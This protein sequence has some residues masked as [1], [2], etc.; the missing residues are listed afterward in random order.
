M[1]TLMIIK[2][3]LI[4]PH[5]SK[6]LPS[7]VAV[8]L[9]VIAIITLG[10]GFGLLVRPSQLLHI[11]F[12]TYYPG[13]DFF[14]R[15]LGST[16]VGYAGLNAVAARKG[17]RESMETAVWGNLITLTIATFVSIRYTHLFSHYAWLMIGQHVVF[18]SGFAYCA[19]LLKKRT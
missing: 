6:D 9:R 5:A 13:T 8:Y 12:S 16:L 10:L 7:F 3:V 4:M 11:F 17:T 19:W 15:M 14:V 2:T 18:V 1:A